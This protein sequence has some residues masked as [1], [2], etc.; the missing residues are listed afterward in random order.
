MDSSYRI[1]DRLETGHTPVVIDYSA[2]RTS[3]V[4]R[5]RLQ[6]NQNGDIQ[7]SKK[8]GYLLNLAACLSFFPV[9]K[10]VIASFALSAFALTP[11]NIVLLAAFALALLASIIT[12]IEKRGTYNSMGA[13]K[14]ILTN[15]LAV[16]L[17]FISVPL[18]AIALI[19]KFTKN[20]YEVLSSK[21]AKL[22]KDYLS[23]SYA[24]PV[25]RVNAN[26]VQQVL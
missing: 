22:P 9:L 11:L 24:E 7:M 26:Y 21:R 19:A 23:Y 8:S 10:I 3:E 6:A 13:F 15:S 12:L 5:D 14:L 18:L 17:S 4:V 2:D 16:A 20:R 25:R 1:T